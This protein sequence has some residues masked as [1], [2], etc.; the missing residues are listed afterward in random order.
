MPRTRQ[1]SA[2]V[3]QPASTCAANRHNPA[4]RLPSSCSPTVRITKDGPEQMQAGSKAEASCEVSSLLR[5]A[6][7]A[8]AAAG[9][10]PPTKPMSSTLPALRLCRPMQR[11]T[12]QS[13]TP[14]TSPA[15]LRM[16]SADTTRKGNNDTSS[17]PPQSARPCRRAAAQVCGAANTSSAV[18]APSKKS[19][20]YSGLQLLLISM[21]SPSIYM[22]AWAVQCTRRG[23]GGTKMARAH[24]DRR[25]PGDWLR[26]LFRQPPPG[27]YNRPA[28]YLSGDRM[29]IEHFCTVLFFD[30]NRL[31]L[32][33]AKGRFT[34][35]G[36]G[37]RICTLTAAR[38]TVQGQFLRTD[39]SDE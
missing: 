20:G 25:T 7:A 26:G 19:P 21:P 16:M 6:S 32:R 23:T 13:S 5:T 2:A 12:G 35:Y 17:G 39:F 33:L 1:S 18:A 22:E 9:A 34:V 31:C 15:P 36:S 28:V 27:F 4:V 14:S 10:K 30:E 29:E 24:H 3:S 8:A 37:L 38:L 11:T